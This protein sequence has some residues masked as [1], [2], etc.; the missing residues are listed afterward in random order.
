MRN[1]REVR[2]VQHGKGSTHQCIEEVH[3][4]EA[5]KQPAVEFPH[6]PPLRGGVQRNAGGD[7]LLAAAG[8]G[9]DDTIV[10]KDFL[11]VP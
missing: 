6:Q 7:M 9:P 3:D 11:V 8:G 10:D 5:R 2:A 4:S 1:E